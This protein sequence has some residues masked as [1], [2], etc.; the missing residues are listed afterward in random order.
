MIKFPPRGL[1]KRKNRKGGNW[2]KADDVDWSW[3][4]GEMKLGANRAL[5]LDAARPATN[6]VR[7]DV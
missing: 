6:N 4:S 3:I 1:A 2:M 5:E 7:E